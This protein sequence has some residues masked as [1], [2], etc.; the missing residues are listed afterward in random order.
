MT[1][2]VMKEY[3][4]KV[5]ILVLGVIMLSATAAAIVFP[6]LKFAGL[7]PGVSFAIIGVFIAV[8]IAEDIIG[9]IL[10]RKSLE[11]EVL[12]DKFEEKV[13]NYF[14]FVLLLN[15]N[16]ITWCFPSKESWMFAFYFLVLMSFFLD[17]KFI[18]ICGLAEAVSLIILFIGN[19]VARPVESMFW[20]DSILRTIC[21]TLSLAGMVAVVFFVN[22]FL[23]NA[24][25]EQLESNNARVENVLIRVTDITRKLVDASQVLVGTSQSESA[26]TEELSAISESLLGTSAAMIEKTEQSQ[27]NLSNLEASSKAMGEK[28][29]NVDAVSK[30]L[31]D[32]SEAN[33]QAL[34][35]LLAV[36]K[37]VELSTNETKKVTDKLLM[38][39]GE[40]GKTLD[41]INDIA[42]SINLLALNA[43]IEAARA[44]EA[45]RGF[46]VVAQE[47]GHLAESTKDSLK[48]VND[49]VTRVQN[50]TENVSRI[51]NENTTQ[52]L[53]QNKLIGET[54]DGIR[55]M[56]DLL[57]ESVKAIKQA[58]TICINQNTI[59][60]ETVSINEDIAKCI[61]NENNE[62]SNIASMVQGNTEEIM[63]LSGQVDVINSMIKELE[64]L[65]DM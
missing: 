23:L 15:L 61:L 42:E 36:S 28:M 65:L 26:S 19:P 59:I 30:G 3:T 46:A 60:S 62:F 53:A 20:S 16:L 1:N 50:G 45:G 27:S 64:E 6:V 10:I 51:M 54:V 29:Q 14:L 11:Q 34:N 56:M 4:K 37:K 13:K 17:L 12:E 57:K 44:G 39:S 47:V 40:I 41:I 5:T 8:I 9:A 58:D 31:V 7:Y 48:N 21:I 52:Q 35:E 38:E 25:K 2:E 49:V 43:S 63:T 55:K 32:I 22:K 33:E 18:A 24:K